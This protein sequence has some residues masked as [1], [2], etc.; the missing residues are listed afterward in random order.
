MKNKENGMIIYETAL[1]VFAAV[2]SWLLLF[3]SDLF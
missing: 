1:I 2:A 3:Q